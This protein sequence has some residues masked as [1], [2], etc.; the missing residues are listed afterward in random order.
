MVCPPANGIHNYINMATK[1]L[2][3]IGDVFMVTVIL[4]VSVI[5]HVIVFKYKRFAQRAARILN[6]FFLFKVSK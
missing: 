1:S 5:C 2:T 6:N 3:Y 4:D